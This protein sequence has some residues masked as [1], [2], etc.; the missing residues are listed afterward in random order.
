MSNSYIALSMPVLQIKLPSCIEGGL[1]ISP[2]EGLPDI[3]QLC[4]SC[5]GL[6]FG[7]LYMGDCLFKYHAFQKHYITK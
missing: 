2:T 6:R 7:A 4:T 5:H 3:V 1:A